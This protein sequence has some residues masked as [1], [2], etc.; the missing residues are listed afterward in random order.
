MAR[1]TADWTNTEVAHFESADLVRTDY[2]LADVLQNIEHIA[3]LH[4]HGG[5]DVSTGFAQGTYVGDGSASDRLI[6]VPFQ[7]KVVIVKAD[8]ATN[9]H[10]LIRTDTLSQAE[11]LVN[12]SQ[13]QGISGLVAGGFNVKHV[14]DSNGRAN[15]SG[16]TYYW[17][18]WGGDRLVTGTYVGDGIDGHAITGTGSPV[19]AWVIR[20]ALNGDKAFR[21]SSMGAEDYGFGTDGGATDR[22]K[23]LDAD[24]FTL[25]VNTDVNEGAVTYHYVVF[26]SAVNLAVGT[27]T[28]DGSD[29]RNLPASAMVF[30]PDYVNIK[31]DA[32]QE[33]TFKPTALAGDAALETGSVAS[34]ANLIQSLTPA[35]GKFQVGS[36]NNTNANLIVYYFFAFG[37]AVGSSGS[38]DAPG[39]PLVLNEAEEILFRMGAA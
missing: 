6:S 3:Q 24:G 10:A 35:S 23:T 16:K 2:L 20:P 21:T 28:G 31:A 32:A 26:L 33:M 27:Y 1:A 9:G 17:Q 4:N 38:S 39:G 11:N 13:T 36:D 8:H 7:P 22:I 34:A 5:D 25:G 14:A 19:M 15:E 30:D 18:A 29:S 12:S 37:E